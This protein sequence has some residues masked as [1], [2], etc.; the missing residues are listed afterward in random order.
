[1]QKVNITVIMRSP[2]TA[3]SPTLDYVANFQLPEHT[4]SE[5]V[6]VEEAVLFLRN[7]WVRNADIPELEERARIIEPPTSPP[8]SHTLHLPASSSHSPRA[9]HYSYQ[10]GEPARSRWPVED[11]SVFDEASDAADT[12]IPSWQATF[13]QRLSADSLGR[14][15]LLVVDHQPTSDLPFRSAALRHFDS[16]DDP[17]L[18]H[19]SR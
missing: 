13:T 14:S 9:L 18:R 16:T 5:V 6:S 8:F 11:F 1:M 17:A 15:T 10:P 4:F 19:Y 7:I 2:I 3:P 12:T